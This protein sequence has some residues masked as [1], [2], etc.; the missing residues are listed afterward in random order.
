MR[1]HEVFG[2]RN[3]R[4]SMKN[5]LDSLKKGLHTLRNQVQEWK[6]RIEADLKAGK[7]ISESDEEWLDGEGKLIGEEQVVGCTQS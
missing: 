4:F 5:P 3:D 2:H 7:A 1:S 6:S